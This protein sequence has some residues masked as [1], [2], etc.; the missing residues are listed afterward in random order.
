MDMIAPIDY[1]EHL[2]EPLLSDGFYILVNFCVPHHSY[3]RFRFTLPFQDKLGCDAIR[4]E[5]IFV[6]S[7]EIEVSKDT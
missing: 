5:D 4:G 3:Q 2:H 6:S 1:I 7:Y